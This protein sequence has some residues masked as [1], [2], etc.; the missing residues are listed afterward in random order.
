MRKLSQQQE[1]LHSD[2]AEDLEDEQEEII[3]IDATNLF[4]YLKS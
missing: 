1:E 2:D 3:D 4:Q